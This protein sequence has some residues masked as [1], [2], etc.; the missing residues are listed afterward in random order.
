[1]AAAHPPDSTLQKLL[2][3]GLAHN[4][5]LD[6]QLYD[7]SLCCAAPPEQR[8][9]PPT[10]LTCI[11]PDPTVLESEEFNLNPRDQVPPLR[12]FLLGTDLET[13]CPARQTQLKALM[14][15]EQRR[16]DRV[17]QRA[18]QAAAKRSGE[19]GEKVPPALIFY[20][21]ER[22]RPRSLLD[23]GVAQGLES[24]N[25]E[26]LREKVG[27]CAFLQFKCVLRDFPDNYPGRVSGASRTHCF[28]NF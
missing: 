24:Q 20:A 18:E 2:F 19:T 27:S 15:K 8:H 9:S 26:K 25:R 7:A 23:P 17:L 4:T 11:N 12:R 6:E 22:E 21:D 5:G 3:R 14:L 13:P 16:M 28:S 1:M 10:H